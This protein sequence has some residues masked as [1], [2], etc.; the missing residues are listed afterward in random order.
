MENNLVVEAEA[1]LDLTAYQTVIDNNNPGVQQE[2]STWQ[3][4]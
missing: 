1:F 3:T 4:H 2:K